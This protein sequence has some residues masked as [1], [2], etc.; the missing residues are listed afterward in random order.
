MAGKD[1]YIVGGANSAGQS[2]LH[3]ARYARRVTLLVRAHRST[4]DV[5]YL[6]REV[7]AAPN[8]DVRVGTEVAGGGGDGR[9]QQLV[10][11]D[12]LTGEEETVAADGLFVMIGARPHTRLAAPGN[13]A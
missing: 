13:S 1:A 9:L 4:R 8:V 10:L 11:R 7:E 12:C 3:L 5:H 6:V 2:A